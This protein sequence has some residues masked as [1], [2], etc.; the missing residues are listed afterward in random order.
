MNK[1]QIASYIRSFLGHAGFY[2]ALIVTV[3]NIIISI[4][5]PT[6]DMGINTI[7]SNY[8]MLFC[9]I[10][11]LCDFVMEIKFIESYLAKVAIHFVLVTIDFAVVI[12]WLSSPARSA[13][14]VVFAVLIFAVCFAVVDA[15]RVIIHYA[16]SKKKNEKQEYTSL[17]T[18][19]QK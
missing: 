16:T 8:I 18:G 9:A 19:E 14:T 5:F 12:A 1:K 10:F 4:A 2:F 11:A 7:M 6:G 15:V 17:F 3:C 13:K